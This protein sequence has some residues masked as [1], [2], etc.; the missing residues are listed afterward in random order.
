MTA[1]LQTFGTTPEI[2]LEFIIAVMTGSMAVEHLLT[3]SV[4]IGSSSHDL[5][6]EFMI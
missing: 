1:D 6:G 4:G 5:F 2:R 3:K